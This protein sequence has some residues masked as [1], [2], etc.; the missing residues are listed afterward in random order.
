MLEPQVIAYYATRSRYVF[1]PGIL[2]KSKDVGEY[3]KGIQK[4]GDEVLLL[5]LDTDFDAIRKAFF[6]PGYWEGRSADDEYCE[7]RP[8]YA[9]PTFGGVMTPDYLSDA[10]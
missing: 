9:P 4:A 1:E 3:I 8:K 6:G 7:K 10:K 5:S 2:I